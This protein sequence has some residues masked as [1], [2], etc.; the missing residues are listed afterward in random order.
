L[1]LAGDYPGIL[2]AAVRSGTTAGL[3]ISIDDLSS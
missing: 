2:E 1:F 3:R